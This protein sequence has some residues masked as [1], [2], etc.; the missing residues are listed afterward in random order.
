MYFPPRE[1]I[2]LLC[3]HCSSWQDA[4]Q[5]AADNFTAKMDRAF[6]NLED[7]LAGSFKSFEEMDAAMEQAETVSDRFLDNGKKQYELS[8]LNRK[9]Q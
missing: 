3:L 5:V 9:L 7:N 4:L 6:E 1:R 2:L 8:K